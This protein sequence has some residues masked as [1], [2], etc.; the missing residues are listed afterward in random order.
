MDVVRGK[1]LWCIEDPKGSAFHCTLNRSILSYIQYANPQFDVTSGERCPLSLVALDILTGAFKSS[2]KLHLGRDSGR[3]IREARAHPRRELIFVLL[4]NEIMVFST[5][6]MDWVG[7]LKLLVV[8][9]SSNHYLGYSPYALRGGE[10]ELQFDEYEPKGSARDR[11]S[12]YGLEPLKR[13]YFVVQSFE[14]PTAEEL[15]ALSKPDEESVDVGPEASH[16]PIT[17]WKR[18]PIEILDARGVMTHFMDH[19]EIN[20]KAK[21]I[22]VILPS[23]NFK[24]NRAIIYTYKEETQ[25]PEM[26]VISAA[27]GEGSPVRGKGKG[28]E[29]SEEVG[30][31][32]KWFIPSAKSEVTKMRKN[33]PKD[34]PYINRRM[35]ASLSSLRGYKGPQ[36]KERYMVFDQGTD[37]F[38]SSFSPPW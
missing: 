19:P 22:A 38:L 32:I 23:S 7:A 14:L 35:A 34:T 3:E 2:T 20:I 33:L 1:L 27:A 25:V 18:Q 21:Q 9:A 4:C 28:K 13:N 15:E 12:A 24:S 11:V 5:I 8:S 17:S 37:V 29:K 10:W 31:E 30:A 16:K 6:T 26:F 36:L